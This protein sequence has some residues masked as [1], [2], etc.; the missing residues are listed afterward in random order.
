MLSTK[1]KPWK[2]YTNLKQGNSHYGISL[3]VLYTRENM[4]LMHYLNYSSGILSQQQ[5]SEK[6]HMELDHYNSLSMLTRKPITLP[7]E[8]INLRNLRK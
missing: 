5:L 7:F 4:L 8:K 2:Q 1:A 3:K 6:A